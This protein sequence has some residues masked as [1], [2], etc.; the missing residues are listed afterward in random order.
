MSGRGTSKNVPAKKM[1]CVRP[2]ED[3]EIVIHARIYLLLVNICRWLS[4]P[5]SSVPWRSPCANDTRQHTRF[6]VRAQGIQG[7]STLP[8]RPKDGVPISQTSKAG[9]LF[10][11]WLLRGGRVCVNAPAARHRL[12]LAQPCPADAKGR[13]LVLKPPCE[14]VLRIPNRQ[15]QPNHSID[16]LALATKVGFGSPH[17]PHHHRPSP[18]A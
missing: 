9:M 12:H 17:P 8:C 6:C 18:A 4:W 5:P 16:L 14:L 3:K 2:N 1:A 11:G 13:K 7:T 10:P 15:R